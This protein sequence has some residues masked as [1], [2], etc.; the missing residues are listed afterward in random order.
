MTLRFTLWTT[1]WPS[2]RSAPMSRLSCTMLTALVCVFFVC[3]CVYVCVRCEKHLFPFPS[4]LK[5]K[6]SF[7]KV[8]L[9]PQCPCNPLLFT[10]KAFLCKVAQTGTRTLLLLCKYFEVRKRK[11]RKKIGK[12]EREERKEKKRKERKRKDRKEKK[13][14][15]REK[16]K[17]RNVDTVLINEQ[18][19][20]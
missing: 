1:W 5:L 15:K 18:H 8:C 3:V 4:F 7:Q 10:R 11:E 12:K 20:K 13:R 6:T 9:S 2:A 17:E 19:R 16:G 14:K